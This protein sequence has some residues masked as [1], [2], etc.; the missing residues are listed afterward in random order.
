[1]ITD[2]ERLEF[3]I[4]YEA[5]VGWCRDGEFCDVYQSDWENGYSGMNNQGQFFTD[6]RAAIDTAIQLKEEQTK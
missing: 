5:H 4:K 6:P 3:L 2:T 1:M